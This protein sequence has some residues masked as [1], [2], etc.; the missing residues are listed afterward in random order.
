MNDSGRCPICGKPLEGFREG[1]CAG[2]LSRGG[3]DENGAGGGSGRRST[4][5][6]FRVASQSALDALAETI[7]DVPHVL[8]P[9]TDPAGGPEPIEQMGSTERPSSSVDGGVGRYVLFGEIARGGMGAI[10]RARDPDLGRDL[11]L[12]VLLERHRDRPEL[13]KRFLEE[14]QIEGQLQHPGIV[15]IHEL[16]TL[17]DRRPFFAMKLVKGRTLAALLAARADVAEDLP[18]FLGIFEQVAQTMAYAHSR[19]VIHRDLKPSNIMVGSF[20][21]VQVMDWGLAKVLHRGGVADEREGRRVPESIIETIRSGSDADASRAGSVLG[22]PAY[23]S[24]QQARGDV[25]SL[26]ERCDVFSLGS[27]LCEIL[28][29]RPP[30]TGNSPNEILEKTRRADL[31]EAHARLDACGADAELTGLARDWMAPEPAMRPRDAREVAAAMTAYLVGV[32]ERLRTAE[33]AQVAA[34]GRAR[35]TAT[36]AA[37]VLVIALTVGGGWGWVRHQSAARQ[38]R[39]AREVDGALQ[40]ATMLWG[41][42]RTAPVGDLA[43]W[44]EALGAAKRASALLASGEGD[45]EITR[46]VQSTLTDLSHEHDQANEKAEATARDRRLVERLGAIRT[47]I[48]DSLDRKT[49]EAEFSAA[50]REAGLDVDASPPGEVGAR[51]AARPQAIEISEAIDEWTFNRLSIDPADKPG[52]LG[53][54]EVA[55]AADPDPWRSSLRDA[56]GRNDLAA[57]KRL[58][59]SADTAKLPVESAKRLGNKLSLFGDSQAAI[60]VLLP[61]QR[62]HPGDFWLNFDLGFAY[63]TL[64][65]PRPE[66]AVHFPTRSAV[67]LRPHLS[68]VSATPRRSSGAPRQLAGRYDDAIAEIKEALRLQPDFEPAHSVLVSLLMDAGR[69]DEAMAMTRE[70]IR[71]RPSLAS[72]RIDLARS[73]RMAG[74]LDEALAEASEAIRLKPGDGY[75]HLIRGWILLGQKVWDGSISEYKQAIQLGQEQ[76][77]AVHHELGLAYKEKTQWEAAIA[78]LRNAVRL[79]PDNA[80]FRTDLA[81]TLRHAGR[82]DEALAESSEAIRL[83]PDDGYAHQTR[84]WVLLGR[85]DWDGATSEYRK[86]IRLGQDKD[87]GVRHGLGLALLNLGNRDEAAE[88]FRVAIRLVPGFADHYYNLGLSLSLP[89][90]SDE[91]EA[92]FR[93]AIRLNPDYALAYCHLGFVLRSRGDYVGALAMLRKGH[94]LGV[95]QPGWS[96]PSA[97][98]VAEAERLAAMAARIPAMLKG[99]DT[100]KNLV[101]SMALTQMLFDTRHYAA[102]ARFWSDVLRTDPKVGESRE[103][104]VR[105]NAACA[106]CLAVAGKGKDEPPLDDAAR[107]KLRSLAL[108]WLTAELATWTKLLGGGDPKVR[109]R[110]AETMRHWR[111]DG[112]LVSVRDP[113]SLE[114]LPEAERKQWQSLWADVDA[115]GKRSEAPAP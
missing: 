38:A 33:L 1:L 45:V 68:R 111:A 55:K 18:R 59:E 11:A 50:F 22:T 53:L 94:E 42:A 92:A 43:V 87:G 107:A 21:E 108:D 8:L 77:P 109:A 40:E 19:S 69:L 101:E 61:V 17:P 3:V 31:G 106:A 41:R 88:E 52:A 47:Q 2:C 24:P 73:L 44:G 36:V 86:A 78:S 14:A 56:I 5:L 90:K 28:S 98:W 9:D 95:K 13:I 102:A 10:L 85:N 39:T 67:S 80:T 103:S 83:K 114:K 104:G 79:R 35:L 26:D 15:P 58:A 7:G 74:R 32:Q 62:Y 60:S 49:A 110:V 89:E 54:I 71:R 84:A 57:F 99:E 30:F 34:Q 63:F 46:R 76:E 113:Q 6:P 82:L 100:P 25:E 75:A 12:K 66:E 48:G 112:D 27:I 115:L 65:P 70:A 96:F 81:Q 105:Y 16:G 51:I 93:E 29:G 4:T 91:A 23:M 20:G 37:S 97:R 72:A 64:K